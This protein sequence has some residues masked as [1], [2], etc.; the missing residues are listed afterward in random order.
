MKTAIII[1]SLTLAGLVS[2]GGDAGAFEKGTNHNKQNVASVKTGTVH[3]NTQSSHIHHTH[4]R[5]FRGFT[6]RCW[7]PRYNCYAYFCPAD[8]MWF[9][10]SPQQMAFLPVGSL[11]TVPPVPVAGG[12]APTVAVPD[13]GGAGTP[14]LPPGGTGTPPGGGAKDNTKT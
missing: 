3:K 5:A 2:F 6:Y 14:A 13:V 1:A 11:G 7:L 4:D 12:S 9:F 8:G 10:W